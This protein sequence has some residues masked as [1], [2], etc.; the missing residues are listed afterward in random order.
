MFLQGASERISSAMIRVLPSAADLGL[1]NLKEITG[2]EDITPAHFIGWLCSG[3]LVELILIAIGIL[4]LL[5]I[6]LRFPRFGGFAWLAFGF[7]VCSGIYFG[8]IFVLKDPSFV[9]NYVPIPETLGAVSGIF[10]Q[11][12]GS[13]RQYAILTAICAG[14]CI[15]IKVIGCL[16]FKR[17]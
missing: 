6:V 12:S 7:L 10:A 16:I 8:L 3:E 17:K 14:F 1:S 2:L 15:V 5:I 13:F 11:V 4:A 9:L